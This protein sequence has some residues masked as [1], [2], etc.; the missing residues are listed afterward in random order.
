MKKLM[1]Y[2]FL[3][4]GLVTIFGACRKDDVEPPPDL[5]FPLPLITMD[6]T[7]DEFISGRD[8]A[9]FLGKFVVDMYY[10][11]AVKPQKIDVVVIKN[12]NKAN[13]KT[14][15]A[16]VT[17]FPAPIQVTGIQLA[18]LFDSTIEL[19]DKFEI[20]ADV[21]T[22]NGQ[23]FEAFPVTGNPYGADTAALPGSS[24]S[25]VY[26]TQCKFDVA[27][28]NGFYT[29]Q[30]NTWD[31]NVGDQIEVRPGAVN[32]IA[33]TAWPHP[34]IGMYI[35]WPMTIFVDLET[36]AVT[37]PWQTTGEYGGG[38]AVVIEGGTGTVSPCGDSIT[39]SVILFVG[40][41]PYA[42][43]VPLVLRK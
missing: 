5:R 15:K 2:S 19:G 31:F 17:S 40:Y 10:G 34:D 32:S 24:F 35:R 1:L 16:D 23:K 12:D 30:V 33:I 18:T 3:L 25:I 13:V 43:K 38:P 37:I 8:P 14:I 21:T 4:Y 28:F 20:G 27:Y 7:G 9:S 29:V 22:I 41:Y 11:T 42:G 36:F 39:L 26:V 6:T